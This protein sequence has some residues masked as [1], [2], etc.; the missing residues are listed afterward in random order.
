MLNLLTDRFFY[1]KSRLIYRTI[2]LYHFSIY[3]S[4]IFIRSLVGKHLS[5]CYLRSFYVVQLGTAHMEATTF[6]HM[7]CKEKL[8]LNIGLTD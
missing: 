8:N 1:I 7:N 5:D 4:L 3:D 6:Q 2:Y